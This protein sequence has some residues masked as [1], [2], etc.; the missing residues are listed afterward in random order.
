MRQAA[1]ITPPPTT[2]GI[3]ENRSLPRGWLD[4]LLDP[5]SFQE[6]DTGRVHHSDGPGMEHRRIPGDGV[7]AGIGR[8]GGRPVAVY[9]QDPT[10]MGGALGRVQ[11]E[12]I[13]R[14]LDLADRQRFPVIGLVASGGARIQEGVDSL[15]GYGMV[16]HHTVRLS[17]R[18]PQI[19][20]AMGTCAGGAVYQP[21]LTDFVIMVRGESRMFITGPTVVEAV[22][23]ERVTAE[24][25]GGWRRHARDSGL[26]GLVADDP[27]TAFAQVRRLLSFLDPRRKLTV[28]AEAGEEDPGRWVPSEGR[29]TYDVRRLL[30]AV[31]DRHSLFEVHD[32]F[33]RNLVTAFARIEGIRVGI[34]ANQPKVLGGVLDSRSSRKGAR[35]VRL[36]NSFGL[37]LITFVDCPGYLPG[38]RAER[39]GITVHGAKLLYA[40]CEA[41]VPRFT[42]VVRKGFGGAFIVLGSRSIGA[43]AAWAWPE[44]RIGVMG[45]RGAVDI[46]HRRELA[47]EDQPVGLRREL[48]ERYEEQ[49]LHPAEAARKGAIDGIIAP[50]DTRRVLATALRFADPRPAELGIFPL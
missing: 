47:D 9:A 36:C 5:A 11:A 18:V 46:L 35:F 22:T 33:A 19:T 29:H 48:E 14:V 50:R 42:V 2:A 7:V 30:E 10:V 6:F 45:A 12:K 27:E 20:I 1:R 16:F 21:A 13:C 32:H 39:D 3:C 4:R 38:T 43:Q 24:E 40:Y 15:S 41:T 17:G 37:P 23:H 28:P 26:C 34:V 31:V 8:I 49:V 44:A 25:L